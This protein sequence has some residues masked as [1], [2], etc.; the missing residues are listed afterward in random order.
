MMM[1]CPEASHDQQHQSRERQVHH[2]LN[3]MVSNLCK[4][5]SLSPPLARSL[6]GLPS[7]KS[8]MSVV[9]QGCNKPAFTK[10]DGCA[11]LAFARK[12]GS[13]IRPEGLCCVQ[14]MITAHNHN[15]RALMEHNHRAAIVMDLADGGT[16][17]VVEPRLDVVR[18][19]A[20][21]WLMFAAF[22]LIL[23]WGVIWAR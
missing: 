14:R 23:P 6:T 9:Y 4:L 22:G 16:I 2:L 17:R 10:S 15:Y 8:A 20:H 13:L 21:A 3:Q 19:Q 7:S 1:F 11:A 5:D 12:R 18:V